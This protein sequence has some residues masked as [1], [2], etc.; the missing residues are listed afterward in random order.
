MGGEKGQGATGDGTRG[1][2]VLLLFC[3]FAFFLFYFE[4]IKVKVFVNSILKC[5]SHTFLK[6]RF[7][8][9]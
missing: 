5:M 8:G 2:R 4:V 1:F 7:C 3:L 9:M 6:G